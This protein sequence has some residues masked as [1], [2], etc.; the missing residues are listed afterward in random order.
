MRAIGDN[1]AS[2]HAQ[3]YYNVARIRIA[4]GAGCSAMSAEGSPG[5]YLML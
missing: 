1:P 2:T 3:G 4:D 5:A